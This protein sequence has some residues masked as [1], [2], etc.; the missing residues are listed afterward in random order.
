MYNRVS[1][2]NKSSFLNAKHGNHYTTIKFFWEKSITVD[3]G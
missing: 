3:I 2:L 1:P